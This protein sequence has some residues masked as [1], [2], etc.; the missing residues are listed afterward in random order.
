MWLLIVVLIILVVW[1]AGK[2]LSYYFATEGLLY[3]LATKYDDLL[4]IEKVRELQQTA[5]RKTI[6]DWFGRRR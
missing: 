4:E 6:Q 1:L 5:L 3:Y 2:W